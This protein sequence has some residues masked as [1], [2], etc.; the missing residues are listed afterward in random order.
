[1][2]NLCK[3]LIFIALTVLFVVGLS[4]CASNK[5]KGNGEEV[6]AADGF[7]LELNGD[8]DSRKAGAL[9]TVY[10]P[11]DSNEIT[12]DASAT[13]KA[14]A[15]FLK[16]NKG[17]KVQV[18]GHCDERGS[19]QYNLALG[20]KRAK[21]TRDFLAAEGVESARISVISYGKEKAVAYGHDD[22]A[23]SKNRRSNF[24]ITEK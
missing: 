18:E 22:A 16:N 12:A 1:M 20:E 21:A 15:E 6:A 24:V 2:T 8:S 3:K 10:F 23:W 13:L 4:S 11:F 14:N 17:I 19:I 5:G 9:Q 7:T